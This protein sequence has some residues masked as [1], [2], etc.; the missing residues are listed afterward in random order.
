MVGYGGTCIVISDRSQRQI[1]YKICEKYE[2]QTFDDRVERKFNKTFT[3]FSEILEKL[4]DGVPPSKILFE[5]KRSLVYSQ[6]YIHALYRFTRKSLADVME[7]Y[8]QLLQKGFVIIDINCRNFGYDDSSKL[9]LFDIHSFITDLS[10]TSQTH[11]N[12][13]IL[14][15][16][17][18][19]SNSHLC[20]RTMMSSILDFEDA[21]IID[22]IAKFGVCYESFAKGMLV[23]KIEEAVLIACRT[24]L[25]S[26]KYDTYQHLTVDDSMINLTSHTLLKYE[27]VKKLVEQVGSLNIT[28]VLDAGCAIGAIGN[29]LA[30]QYPHLTVSLNNITASELKMAKEMA[31]YAG[32]ENVSF[33]SDNIMTLTQQHDL[34]LY[35]ALFHHLLRGSTI[36]IILEALMKQVKKYAVVEVPLKGDKLLENV[37]GVEL[38]GNFKVLLSADHLRHELLKNFSVLFEGPIVYPNS[39]D[40]FRHYFVIERL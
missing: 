15:S 25:T 5:D 40:L 8:F 11:L 18:E 22:K 26:K 29:T 36:D 37:G 2:R 39:P 19:H 20:T 1:V 3:N 12:L 38:E 9:R 16:A 31:C 24:D 35:F 4:G 30:Q 21:V 14:L 27:I 33:S 32:L 17:L 6:D 28:S 10:D 23:N 7:I 13:C 34:G